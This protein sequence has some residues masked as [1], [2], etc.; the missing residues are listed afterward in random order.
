MKADS[1]TAIALF[2][3]VNCVFP[4]D[5]ISVF[6]YSVRQSSLIIKFVFDKLYPKYLAK[7]FLPLSLS[8]FASCRDTQTAKA[9]TDNSLK[10]FL[11]FIGVRPS[12]VLCLIGPMSSST[13]ILTFFIVTPFAKT[14]VMLV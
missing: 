2:R 4:S 3:S 13:T 14:V 8:K 10:A 12:T 6:I 5:A 1:L 11:I 7:V 9:C